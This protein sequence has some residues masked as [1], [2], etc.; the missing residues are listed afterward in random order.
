MPQMPFPFGGF[1]MG[2]NMQQPQAVMPQLPPMPFP[3]GGF[4]MGGNMQQPQAVMP[5]L[6]PMPFMFPFPMPGMTPPQAGA[7]PQPNGFPFPFGFPMVPFMPPFP[8][9]DMNSAPPEQE[10]EKEAP[11]GFDFMGMNISPEVLQKLLNIDAT[12]EQLEELQ[13][14]LDK[15]YAKKDKK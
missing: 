5:Q 15:A 1:P 14:F 11:K 13:K 2:G 4:P 8:T 10:E 12:P 9:G 6:P 3:F 7:A